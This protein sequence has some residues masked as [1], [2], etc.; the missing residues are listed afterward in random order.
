MA[1]ISE[2]DEAK[3]S[4]WYSTVAQADQIGCYWL[5]NTS[6]VAL[7][8]MLTFLSTSHTQFQLHVEKVPHPPKRSHAVTK[9]SDSYAPFI[10]TSH[11]WRKFCHCLGSSR[12]QDL[13]EWLLNCQTTLIKMLIHVLLYKLWFFLFI[14]PTM[15]KLH[16]RKNFLPILTNLLLGIF[17]KCSLKH[18]LYWEAWGMLEQ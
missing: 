2:S 12:L 18:P 6:P 8:F 10:E 13:W 7:A 17:S 14:S 5:C 15:L 4:V 11:S 1:I 9:E 3:E 16:S